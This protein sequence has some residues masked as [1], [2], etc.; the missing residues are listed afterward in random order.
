MLD[1]YVWG[2]VERISPEA[3]VPVLRASQNTQQ[4]GG[5]ANVAMNLAGLG[6]RVTVMGFGGEDADQRTLE[7]LLH[8]AGVEHTIVSCPGVPTISKL[9]VLAGHQQLLR[10]D[11]EPSPAQVGRAADTLMERAIPAVSCADVVVL[12]DYAK[13]VLT[14]RVCHSIIN[15]AR[16]LHVPVVVDP[17]GRDFTR[18]RGATTICPNARELAAVTGESADALN[19]LLPAGQKMVAALNLQHMLV[20][21]SEK[22]IAILRQGSRTHVPAAARQVFDVS[23]AGDTVVAVI[24][25]AIAAQLPVEAAAHLANV[26]AGIVIGK[27]GTVPIR[28]EELLG[29]LSSGLESDTVEKIVPLELLQSRVAGWRSRGLQVV[30]TNGCFDVLHVGHIALLE[31]AR[32]MGDRLIVGV[33][34]DRSVRSLK[35]RRRPVVYEQDR[36]QV[37]A[38]LAAV[39]AVV[40]F[41]DTTPLRLIEALRPDVLVKGGDYAENEVVGA[42]EV[43][44]W[45][46]RLE[47]VPLVAG[48]STTS[49]IERWSAPA[50]VGV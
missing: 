25:A 16:R 41:D 20:T 23:G 2:K 35:G 42:A 46:G 50:S 48:C 13:G 36:A 14:E 30:F 7:S 3:P 8:E 15:E 39:D 10:M 31:Q 34:S 12:S 26:A 43:L 9:R 11:F 17:K 1:K 29:A 6:A 33:N 45:G 37:L 5:A 24:A 38:A 40:V 32:R 27:V 18:Y 44:G 28:K 22:G 21:L 49:L 4:P 47:L 19:W